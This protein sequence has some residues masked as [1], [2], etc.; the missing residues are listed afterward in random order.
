M[1]TGGQ[2]GTALVIFDCDGVLVDSEPISVS[3]LLEVI[4]EAGLTLSEE[5]AYERFLGVSL[6]ST[7]SILQEEY[8]LVMTAAALDSLR[9]RLY[10][11]FRADLTA[12]TGIAD[13]LDR[14]HQPFC[15][16]SSGQPERIRLSLGLTGLLEK[17]EPHIFSATMVKNGKPA[18]D[19]FLHAAEAMGAEPARCVVVEDSPAGIEAARRAGMRVFAFAGGSHARRESHRDAITRAGPD[20]VFDDMTLLP[21]LVERGLA[22]RKAVP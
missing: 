6:A 16:A 1:T 13:A 18:P 11:R 14:L 9:G 2:A 12:I 20:L 22:A 3:V 19:L 17:F 15:V 10:S 7:C 21:E 5:L 8:D 4:R